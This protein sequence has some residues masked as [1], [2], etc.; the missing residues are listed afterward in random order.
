MKKSIQIPVI[1]GA[2][3]AVT[4]EAKAQAQAIVTEHKDKPAE[5]KAVGRPRKTL[6]RKDATLSGITCTASMREKVDVLM[7]HLERSEAWVIRKLL[8][9]QLDKEIIKHELEHELKH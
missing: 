8:E 7:A 3:P 6:D 1:H 4:A 2:K 9:T 5:K